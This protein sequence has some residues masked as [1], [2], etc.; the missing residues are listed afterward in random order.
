VFFLQYFNFY[1]CIKE[2]SKLPISEKQLIERGHRYSNL[3]D[4]A[5]K[6]Y[7]DILRKDNVW[8]EISA[9]IKRPG[10]DQ[11]IISI[12]NELSIVLHSVMKQHWV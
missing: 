11:I 1:Y 6:Y 10:K 7:H 4:P 5:D 9:I 2:T 8:E 3:Y 12:N